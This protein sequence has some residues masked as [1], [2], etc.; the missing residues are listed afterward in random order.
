M[1]HVGQMQNNVN[2]LSTHC[3]LNTSSS[4]YYLDGI[5]LDQKAHEGALRSEYN[6][7]CNIHSCNCYFKC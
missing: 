2:I 5:D 1:L 7:V 4:V 6:A 3:I